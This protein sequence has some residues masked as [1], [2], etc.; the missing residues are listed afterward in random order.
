MIGSTVAADR[1]CL[2]VIECPPWCSLLLH[3]LLEAAQDLGA[4]AWV[5]FRKIT[6]PMIAAT[7]VSAPASRATRAAGSTSP[8]SRGR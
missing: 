6:L 8:S 1:I 2:I 5:T 4:S 7:T 3:A